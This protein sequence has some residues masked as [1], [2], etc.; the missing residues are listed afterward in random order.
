M[1]SGKSTQLDFPEM[2]TGTSTTGVSSSPSSLISM[3]RFTSK[4]LMRPVLEPSIPANLVLSQSD[5][6]EHNGGWEIGVCS[7][8]VTKSIIACY[9]DARDTAKLWGK[10]KWLILTMGSGASVLFLSCI[11]SWFSSCW[12]AMNLWLFSWV[13]TELILIDFA[14][15]LYSFMED[16]VPGTIYSAIFTNAILSA[17]VL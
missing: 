12:I 7:L 14:Q 8:S 11:F 10:K 16:Q 6:Q 17:F 5:S 3:K 1:L 9:F 13:I 4:V 15:Y 2:S